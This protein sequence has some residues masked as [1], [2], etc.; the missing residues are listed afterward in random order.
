MTNLSFKPIIPLYIMIIF[1]LI[2]MVLIFVNKQQMVSRIIIIVFLLIISQRPVIEDVNNT[3]FNNVDI[4]FVFDTTVSMKAMDVDNY[5]RL[6]SSIKKKK[7]IISEFV[8]A[9]YGIITFNN[10]SSVRVP[11]TSDLTIVND[12]LDDLETIDPYYAVGSTLDLPFENMKA[13]LTSS[14]DREKNQRIVFF[15]SD[16]ED[17]KNKNLLS[18]DKYNE[19]SNLIENGAILGYG[20]ID[21]SKIPVSDSVGK[22]KLADNNGYLL[23]KVN[24]TVAISK[25]NEQALLYLKDQIG[26]DYYHMTS[27]NILNKKLKEIKKNLEAENNEKIVQDKELYYYFAIPML[28]LLLYDLVCY[29]R[30]EQWQVFWKNISL[31]F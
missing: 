21:G 19:L 17:T 13:L 24:N 6:F 12:I 23:D 29:R 16:G 2:M 10:Y 15:I 1:C 4:L 7:K 30:N 20:S 22:E 14:K 11:F 26:I 9:N 3:K 25:L 31:L 8:G 5:S 28:M 18:I 27:F